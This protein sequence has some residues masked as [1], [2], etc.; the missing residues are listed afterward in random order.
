MPVT[1]A[2]VCMFVHVLV[3]GLACTRRFGVGVC[4]TGNMTGGVGVPGLRAALPF[5]S[6]PPGG[7]CG[8][9][10]RKQRAGRRQISDGKNSP[11]QSSIGTD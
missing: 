9:T 4:R 3:C 7:S 10:P 1:R 5:P 8:Q 11:L 6:I 2:R